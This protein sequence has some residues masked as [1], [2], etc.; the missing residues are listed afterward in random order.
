MEVRGSTPSLGEGLTGARL[1]GVIQSSV[2]QQFPVLQETTESNTT[3][4]TSD[5]MV[6]PKVCRTYYREDQ[7]VTQENKLPIDSFSLRSP[8]I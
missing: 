2:P 4:T 8:E 6:G 5:L 7:D 1:I 3:S